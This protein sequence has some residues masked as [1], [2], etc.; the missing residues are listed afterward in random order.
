MNSRKP[1]SILTSCR[2]KPAL[3]ERPFL[4]TDEASELAAMF[5]VLAN[6][7]RLRLLHALVRA[8]EMHVTNLAA[9]LGMKPQAVCNQL[10]R[11]ADRGILGSRRKGL[12]IYYRI[13][14]PCVVDILDH[15]LCLSE[16]AKEQMK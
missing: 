16:D 7:T 10:Q 13:L 14:D 3:Q 6:D 11:L 9:V 2:P 12:N 8:G 4:S 15:G 5:K 1:S